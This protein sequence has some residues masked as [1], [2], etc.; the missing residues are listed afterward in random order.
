MKTI[1]FQESTEGEYNSKRLEYDTETDTY[2]VTLQQTNCN[3]QFE[4]QLKFGSLYIAAK[5]Y[6]ETM[7]YYLDNGNY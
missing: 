1:K 4:T 2:W 3:T 5:V 7:Y 6:N